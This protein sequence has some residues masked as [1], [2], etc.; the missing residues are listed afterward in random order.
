[1]IDRK[2]AGELLRGGD[3]KFRLLAESSADVFWLYDPDDHR[4]LCVSPAYEELWGRTCE[5]L[6]E[7]NNSA[8][9]SVHPDDLERV[10][11]AIAHQPRTGEFDE[12][13]RVVRPD[14]SIRW[15]WNRAFTVK[16]EPGQTQRIVGLGADITERKRA[17]EALRASEDRYR[18]L[19]ELASDAFLEVRP[20]DDI[21]HSNKA[22][23]DM[24]GYT[25]EELTGLSGT[26]D[27]IAPEVFEE[28]ARACREQ[29]EERGRFLVDTLWVR[30]DGS[31]VP[32]S[33]SGQP[34][35]VGGRQQLMLI[36]RDITE[37]E[38]AQQKLRMSEEMIRTM[39]DSAPVGVV[40]ADERGMLIETNRYLQETF[41]YTESELQGTHISELAHPDDADACSNQFSELVL[42]NISRFEMSK[43]CLLKDGSVGWANIMFSAVRRPDH[44]FRFG[45]GM[46]ADITERKRAEEMLRESEQKFRVLAE[47]T[48]DVFWIFDP[49][50]KRSP[51]VSP[52]YEELWG[53][54]RE[55][56]R[57]DSKSWLATVHPDDRERVSEAFEKQVETGEYEA[58][59]RII[60]PDGSL[61]WI[62]DRGFAVKDKSGL[63]QRIVRIAADIT[64]RKR[65]EEALRESEDQFRAIF[66]TAPIGVAI[67]DKD[68]I[69][70]ETNGW[71]QEMFGYA[72]DELRGMRIS[73]LT[74]P[75]D[76]EAYA[77][78]FDDLV[79][80]G[81]SRLQLNMRCLLKNGSAVSANVTISAV[82]G[83]DGTFR[84]GFA[85]I[86][87]VSERLRAEEILRKTREEIE[88]RVELRMRSG[89]AYGL[90]FREFTVLHHVA[91]GKS[92]KE[93]GLELGI[94]PLTVQKH[95]ANILSKMEAGSRTEAGVRAEREGL[96]DELVP[97][98]RRASTGPGT[99]AAKD[100]PPRHLMRGGR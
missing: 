35:V 27:I 90:T 18:T 40:I 5:S 68:G 55:S 15:V 33:V 62:W 9:A 71:L 93:I 77:N 1:M 100:E 13:F 78:L 36:G 3:Q 47:N 51:Y 86:E 99:P 45:L 25:V 23:A 46:I 64:E 4:V 44:T 11:H 32:V 74:H 28:T 16:N 79:R 89:G 53:R 38:R 20:D 91:E 88:S 97:A 29:L 2:R 60:R 75:D 24:L 76:R 48:A 83:P 26:D 56:L 66:N 70:V 52:A 8:L 34:L 69:L 98:A 31:R 54:T 61:R 94:S 30:K 37:R 67:A 95:V 19:Y 80:G 57:E 42:G 82:L 92:D 43:R 87:D 73:D 39:F 14:R 22:A 7:D 58:E 50:D 17:E 49:N 63:T 65:A 96:L 84:F 59:Y 85:M 81:S 21:I 6:Y 41:G 10:T 12:E 72:D